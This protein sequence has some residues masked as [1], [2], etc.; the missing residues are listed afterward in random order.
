MHGDKAIG[1]CKYVI[2][3]IQ[4]IAKKL[5]FLSLLTQV[6]LPEYSA[7]G[8]RDVMLAAALLAVVRVGVQREAAVARTLVAAERV[9]ALVL[10][11][12]IVLGALVH[13]DVIRGCEARAVD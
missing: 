2:Q 12:A 10:A 8:L 4:I 9:A 6:L 13:V 5:I 11:A 7:M 3:I 1:V